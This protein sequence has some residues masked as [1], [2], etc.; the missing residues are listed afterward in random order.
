MLFI[1]TN[2]F[3]FYLFGLLTLMVIPTNGTIDLS[4]QYFGFRA[5]HIVH[6]SVFFPFTLF[7]AF[8]LYNRKKTVSIIRFFFISFLLAGFFES[9]HY[10]LPYRTFSVF[11]F[12]A[13]CIGISFGYLLLLLGRKISIFTIPF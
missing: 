4:G 10:F 11:D 8:H 9:L 1:R 13:N 2:L 12:F 6:S 7:F 5:D 3:Y